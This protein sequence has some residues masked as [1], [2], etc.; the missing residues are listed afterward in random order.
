MVGM[1]AGSSG[2]SL[3]DG[4]HEVKKTQVSIESMYKGADTFNR[5][6]TMQP[7]TRVTVVETEPVFHFDGFPLPC[8][9]LGAELVNN[10]TIAGR[11]YARGIS[12]HG[13]VPHL[14]R[15]DRNSGQVR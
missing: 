15:S 12:L 2:A 9:P 3:H 11:R 10:K 5:G 4:R 14:L 1:L 8:Y 7:G 13:P 6:P